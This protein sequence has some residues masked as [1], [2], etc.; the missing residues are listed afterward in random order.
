MSQCI[1]LHV[2]FMCWKNFIISQNKTNKMQL[3]HCSKPEHNFQ[4]SKKEDLHMFYWK[5]SHHPRTD[6]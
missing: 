2:F 4:L 5:N 3:L 6:S 1:S